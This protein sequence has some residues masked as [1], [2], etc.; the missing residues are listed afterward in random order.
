MHLD[1]KRVHSYNRRAHT[2]LCVCVVKLHWFASLCPS[3]ACSLPLSHQ[4]ATDSIS[5]RLMQ[6]IHPSD[7]ASI[8]R[9]TLT[10]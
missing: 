10:I 9:C 5:Q 6:P 4:H 2:C 7:Q 3:V 1:G 8:E